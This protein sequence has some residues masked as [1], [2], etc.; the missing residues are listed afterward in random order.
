MKK[1]AGKFLSKAGSKAGV[2]KKYI[3][4][5]IFPISHFL[6]FS[7]SAKQEGT[8][9]KQRIA[10][11]GKP[12]FEELQRLVGDVNTVFDPAKCQPVPSVPP[13]QLIEK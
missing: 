1:K 4:Q 12:T 7:K 9:L 13:A 6:L 2:S 3:P 5:K 10:N 8:A 11:G